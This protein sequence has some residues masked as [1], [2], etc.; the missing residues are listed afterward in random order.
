[1]ANIGMKITEASKSDPARKKSGNVS[2]ETRILLDQ[3]EA[4]WIGWDNK[5]KISKLELILFL[6][7]LEAA[8]QHDL[9]LPHFEK[10]E[11]LLTYVNDL[12][13]TFEVVTDLNAHNKKAPVTFNGESVKAGEYP[14]SYDVTPDSITFRHENFTARH[15]SEIIRFAAL[16]F[17]M[18]ENGVTL[19]GNDYEQ[20]L[21]KLAIEDY[22]KTAPNGAKLSINDNDPELNIDIQAQD[23]W[24]NFKKENKDSTCADS[25]NSTN[26]VTSKELQAEAPISSDKSTSDKN[27]N[28]DDNSNSNTQ[29]NDQKWI[30][31]DVNKHPAI[32]LNKIS[33]ETPANPIK[34]APDQL[35]L[36]SVFSTLEAAF[37]SEDIGL[38]RDAL[39]KV[40]PDAQGNTDAFLDKVLNKR[41]DQA[42]KGKSCGFIEKIINSL[43]DNDSE[44]TYDPEAMINRYREAKIE[45]RAA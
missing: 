33:F 45:P 16:D 17:T 43:N 15:A 39:Q 9:K 3:I 31:S 27:S 19:T 24:D 34:T 18:L 28:S 7:A 38:M 6:K 23:D 13:H 11:A 26:P 5:D 8:F 41:F 32:P 1:M 29:D 25:K 35:E 21:L 37:S 20:T 2:K 14:G 12:A 4:D 40:H 36:K 10:S 22:N 30:G 44:K 42:S